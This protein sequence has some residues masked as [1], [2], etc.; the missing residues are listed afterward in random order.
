MAKGKPKRKASPQP[1]SPFAWQGWQLDVPP[2]WNPVLLQGDGRRGSV[3]LADLEVARLELTWVA[4]PGRQTPSLDRSVKKQAAS[5]VNP[6]VGPAD[7]WPLADEFGGARELVSADGDEIRL[8]LNSPASRR[9]AVLRFSPHGLRDH[10]AVVCRI[11]G[12][13][14]DLSD[15]PMVPWAI[16][17]FSFAVPQCVVLSA[18]QLQ[19]GSAVLSFSGRRGELFRFARVT[20]AGRL[21]DRV[22]PV[23]L[24]A[25]IE[26]RSR[27]GY[28]WQDQPQRTHRGHEVVVRHGWQPGL[29]RLR[30]PSRRSVHTATWYCPECDRVFEVLRRGS[31]ADPQRL[32]ELIDHIE[33]HGS[34]PR[35]AR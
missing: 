2:D 10:R 11:V 24:M 26:G 23:E 15:R 3:V 7:P 12:S 33:C 34:T 28:T 5:M 35:S 9:A 4:W 29:S 6:S 25:R 31:R 19:T 27:R 16:Y 18:N 8:V 14:A 20:S 32:L 22:G 21:S 30:R 13:L 1:W 17:G